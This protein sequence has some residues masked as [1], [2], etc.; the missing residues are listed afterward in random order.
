M[1]ELGQLRFFPRPKNKDKNSK[2][3]EED[4]AEGL[5]NMNVNDR[6]HPP[7]EKGEDGAGT[8]GQPRSNRQKRGQNKDSE[9]DQK[10]GTVPPRGTPA[11]AA[12]A[13]TG[14]PT[15]AAAAAAAA[16]ST[17]EEGAP[18]SSTG[19][20]FSS[21]KGSNPISEEEKK[22]SPEEVLKRMNL[23][24]DKN[25]KNRPQALTVANAMVPRPSTSHLTWIRHV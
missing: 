10:A 24:K 22:L 15:P 9:R 21:A 12:T 6:P 16:P 2:N 13:V 23:G 20:T 25:A 5:Y 14:G 8:S 7:M 17:P 1:S 4:A 3:P 19:S 18:S 11:A